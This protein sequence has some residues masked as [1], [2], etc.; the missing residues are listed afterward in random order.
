MRL[1]L[2]A[3]DRHWGAA[4]RSLRDRGWISALQV[5]ETEVKEPGLCALETHRKLLDSREV[6][7]FQKSL[8]RI[9]CGII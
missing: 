1:L 5:V 9:L 2:Q 3:E 6:I 7:L 4:A 8:T